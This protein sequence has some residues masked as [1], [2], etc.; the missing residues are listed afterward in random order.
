MPMRVRRDATAAP[1]SLRLAALQMASGLPRGVTV[2]FVRWQ[3]RGGGEKLQQ[4]LRPHGPG[5][6][7]GCASPVSMQGHRKGRRTISCS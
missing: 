4:P 2:E 6:R 1:P 7:D 5:R 3:E